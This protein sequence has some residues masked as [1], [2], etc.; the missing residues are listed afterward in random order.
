MWFVFYV[1]IY[2]CNKLTLGLPSLQMKIRTREDISER[3]LEGA[4]WEKQVGNP[5]HIMQALITGAKT[6]RESAYETLHIPTTFNS[7]YGLPPEMEISVQV[8]RDQE[9]Y[10]NTIIILNDFDRLTLDENSSLEPLSFLLDYLDSEKETFFSPYCK[11]PLKTDDLIFFLTGNTPIPQTEKFKALRDRVVEVQFQE[12]QQAQK[13]NILSYFFDKTLKIYGITLEEEQKREILQSQDDPSIRKSKIK[14]ETAIVQRALSTNPLS[15]WPIRDLSDPIVILPSPQIVLEQ[16]ISIPTFRHKATRDKVKT[17]DQIQGA[18]QLLNSNAQ[19]DQLKG[20]AELLGRPSWGYI[21]CLWET[22][23]MGTKASIENLKALQKRMDQFQTPDQKCTVLQ[24]HLQL[25]QSITDIL[26][27]KFK[28]EGFIH[29][30]ILSAK[31]KD[32]RKKNLEKL[33]NHLILLGNPLNDQI[34]ID[35]DARKL[36]ESHKR[37]LGEDNLKLSQLKT[38]YDLESLLPA[39][40]DSPV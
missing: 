37:W 16:I 15:L 11:A 31:N 19:E 30:E 24:F 21:E 38:L 18:A 1:S 5:G 20:V 13:F 36:I 27:K 7:K 4:D 34:L 12:F 29:N 22:R 23:K 17:L 33:F 9:S 10:K 6:G 26:I 32:Y 35:E 14:I 3:A 40:Q 28:K 2:F 39:V 8:I 25:A